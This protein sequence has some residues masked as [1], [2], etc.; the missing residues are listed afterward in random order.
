MFYCVAIYLYYCTSL[1]LYLHIQ[2]Y[3]IWIVGFTLS[4]LEIFSS[5]WKKSWNL[6]CE[7]SCKLSCLQLDC[8]TVKYCEISY[9]CINGI[10]EY[11]NE[12][13]LKDNSLSY[14][15]SCVGMLVLLLKEHVA[16]K[17][18]IS[19]PYCANY[20]Y[21]YNFLLYE[22]LSVLSIYVTSVL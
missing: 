12:V 21:S 6:I 13:E 9:L 16:R 10:C 15:C 14:W 8:W 7:N 2:L 22:P 4:H 3:K 17:T 19:P 1:D 11:T 5:L 20:C 18:F